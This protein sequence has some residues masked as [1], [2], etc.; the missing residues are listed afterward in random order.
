MKKKSERDK[1]IST[2]KG[3]FSEWNQETER[4]RKRA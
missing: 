3:F 2:K 1:S 4:K